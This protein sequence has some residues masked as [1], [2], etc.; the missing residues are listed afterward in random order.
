M[1]ANHIY[2]RELVSGIYKELSKLNKT[3]PSKKNKKEK[4]NKQPNLKIE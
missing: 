4:E 2:H 3:I 1:F